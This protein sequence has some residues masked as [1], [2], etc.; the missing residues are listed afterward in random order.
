MAREPR[1]LGTRPDADPTPASGA[2]AGQAGGMAPAVASPV[3]GGW[4]FGRGAPRGARRAVAALAVAALVGLGLAPAPPAA[5]ASSGKTIDLAGQEPP[6][7]GDGWVYADNV[8]TIADGA[9]VVVT[10]STTANR[11]VVASGASASVTLRDAAIDVSGT[12]EAGAFAMGG[13]RVDLV[14]EGDN[15]LTSGQYRPGLEV[16]A[17]AAL[18]I[19]GQGQL[20]ATGGNY[21]AGI[22][23]SYSNSDGGAITINSGTVIATAGYY[24][25]G[26]GGG[27]RM[28]DVVGG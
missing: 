7:N 28:G 26:I 10:G 4:R 21:G 16:P 6:A 19:G 3:R 25:A 11:V 15:T 20:A 2:P 24:G 9:E 23:G 27:G 1:T 17:G 5:A 8:Y 18:T 22:G 12:D 13:A 14:L